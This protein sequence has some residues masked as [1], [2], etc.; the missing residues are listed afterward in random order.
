[1]FYILNK[2]L[3]NMRAYL[4]F[5]YMWNAIK[6]ALQVMSKIFVCKFMLYSIGV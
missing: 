2:S 5:D 4:V 3:H 1:M 6:Y